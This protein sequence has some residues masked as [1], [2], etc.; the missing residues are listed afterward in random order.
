M[1]QGDLPEIGFPGPNLEETMH[2]EKELLFLFTGLVALGT[3]A[4]T[5][6]PADEG[7]KA[8]RVRHFG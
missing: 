1:V 8:G 3:F 4:C 6:E 5:G 2:L 7:Q